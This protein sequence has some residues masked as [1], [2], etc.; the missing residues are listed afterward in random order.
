MMLPVFPFLFFI[1]SI[2]SI[3]WYQRTDNDIFVVLA[4]ASAFTCLIW[5]LIIVHWSIQLLSLIVLL[6]FGSPVFNAIQV[7]VSDK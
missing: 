1:I 2:G 4:A 5:G 6:R 3:F 7:K